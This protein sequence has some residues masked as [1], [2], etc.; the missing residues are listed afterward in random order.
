M[1]WTCSV[2]EATALL[3]ALAHRLV[4]TRPIVALDVE[5]TGP[6]PDRDRIIELAVL[7]V[8]PSGEGR[9][10]QT[11]VNPEEP[12]PAEA[13]AVHGITDDMVRTALPFREIAQRIQAGL[14][15]CDLIAYN[16]RRFDLRIL[17]AEFMRYGFD[18]PL[19]TAKVLDPYVIFQRQAPRDLAAAVRHYIETDA[20]FA[21]HRAMDDVTATIRVLSAQLELTSGELPQSVDALHAFCLHKDPSFIDEAGKIVWRSDVAVIAFG[22]NAGVPLEVL[23]AS[24]PRFL[25]WILRSDFPA[26]TRR[27]VAA[28]LT[29]TFPMRATEVPA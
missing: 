25:E 18:D 2:G 1:V 24:D 9:E 11:L 12:I 27:I 16:A 19:E 3:R 28:A 5:A 14:T 10:F 8:L 7:K 26:D 15:D 29:G 20:E 21:G 6:Y 22:K 4:I 17:H 23:V 13:T